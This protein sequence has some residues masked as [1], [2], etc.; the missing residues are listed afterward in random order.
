M[1]NKEP[2]NQVNFAV[3]VIVILLFLASLTLGAGFICRVFYKIFLAG[4]H[5]L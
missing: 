2:F 3:R 5:A 1:K 4:W